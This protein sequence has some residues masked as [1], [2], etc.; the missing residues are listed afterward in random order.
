[1]KQIEQHRLNNNWT[2]ANKIWPNIKTKYG[3]N[4]WSLKLMNTT[5]KAG[6]CS[7][8]DKSI[9]LSTIL[10][11]GHNCNYDKVKKTLL[12]EVAHALKPGHSHGI[13]WKQKCREIGGDYRLGT[14]MVNVGMNWAVS[15]SKC[16]WREEHLTR[17]NLDGMLC[18]KCHTPI[19]IKRII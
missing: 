17:P 4:G 18:G 9:Y 12:H 2:Y 3:L 14:T 15:C 19:K 13:E 8:V 10:M 1:M 16:K 5:D 11:R 6:M 7:Y